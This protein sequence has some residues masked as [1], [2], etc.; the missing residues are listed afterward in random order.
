[1]RA[2]TNRQGRA[3][4]SPPSRAPYHVCAGVDVAAAEK[5]LADDLRVPTLRGEMKWREA[6][7]RG[8]QNGGT[9][10]LSLA[11]LQYLSLQ[12]AG[13]E[14][15]HSTHK[16]DSVHVCASGQEELRHLQAPSAGRRV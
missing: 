15:P 3:E 14:A 2:R 9:P 10:Q 4:Q 12:R 11:L 5:Q 8:E 13:T 1:M 6:V 16:V 7:L